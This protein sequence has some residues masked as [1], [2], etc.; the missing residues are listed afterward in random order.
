MNII[1][2]DLYTNMYVDKPK[3]HILYCSDQQFLFIKRIYFN[4]V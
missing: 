4:Y 3:I 2:I 1:Y